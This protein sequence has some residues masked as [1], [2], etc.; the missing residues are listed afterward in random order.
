LSDGDGYVVYGAEA[1]AVVGV[2][3]VEAA[4]E[5]GGEAVFECAL[6]GEDGTACRQVYSADQFRR[7]GNFQS[8]NVVGS[9]GAGLYFFHPLGGV[10]SEEVGV[11]G[12]GWFEE[13]SG[14]GDFFL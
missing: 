9:E 12:F 1:F 7:L 11:F 5:V 4:A 13:V 14:F 10:D 3:V 2:G 8:G 6:S